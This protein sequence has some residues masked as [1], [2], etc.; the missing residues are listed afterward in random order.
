MTQR[1]GPCAPLFLAGFANM[2]TRSSAIGCYESMGQAAGKGRKLPLT[3]VRTRATGASRR[4]APA[5]GRAWPS[6]TAGRVALGLLLLGVFLRVLAMASLWPTT[7]LEDGY[8]TYAKSHSFQDPLHPAGYAL[9]LRGIGLVAHNITATVVLQHLAG[10]ITALLL[11]AATRRVTGSYWAA[12]L[13]AGIILLDGDVIYLEQSIMSETWDMLATSIG[14]YAAV[15]SFERPAP[16]TPWP[17]WTGAALGVATTIRSAN[18]V[19]VV[20]AAVALLFAPPST[21]QGWWHRWLGPIAAVGVATIVLVAFAGANAKIG[22]GFGI[23]PSP[24]WYLYGRVAQ[25]ADC[26]QFTPPPRTTSLCQTIPVSQRPG[27]YS[28]MFD[29]KFSPALRLVGTFGKDDRL[30]DSWAERALRAQFG[31][32]LTTAWTY[33]RGYYVPSSLPARLESS[34]TELDPQLDFTNNGNVFFAAAALQSLEHYFGPIKTH[35]I[36]WGRRILR[37]WQVVFRLGATLLSITTVLTLIGLAVGSRRSRFGVLLF[38][39]GGLSLL[40]A[41]VLTGNYV[42]RYTVP[43][44][45][46]LMAAT[47]ITI[48]ELLHIWR[49]S[50]SGESRRPAATTVAS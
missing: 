14:F 26:K 15:R 37:G 30:V 17:F 50:K 42:G 7:I 28:Y 44:A 46:P 39:V 25:F 41:P 4:H 6:G 34:R 40:A 36:N 21:M 3:G 9:V 31:D 49:R 45:G 19:L 13:P 11:G 27:A 32:F 38:G 23:A 10:V 1:L 24:G 5:A 29:P 47:A 2:P 16:L 12:L 18:L 22:N 8:Q 35:Y 20:V 48:T 33:L 43:V